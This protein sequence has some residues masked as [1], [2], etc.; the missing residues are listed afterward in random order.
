VSGAN[1]FQAAGSGWIACPAISSAKIASFTL[2]PLLHVLSIDM[3]GPISASYRILGLQ[4]VLA[5]ALGPRPWT[6][7]TVA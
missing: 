4:V 6:K 2:L 1:A 7:Q 3:L 5:T